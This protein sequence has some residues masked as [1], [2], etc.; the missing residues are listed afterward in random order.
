MNSLL[1]MLAGRQ[2]DSRLPRR[3]VVGSELMWL[4]VLALLMGGCSIQK[5]AVNA[6]GDSLASSGDVF[7]SDE[8]PELV[9]DA[10]PF[11]MKTIEMLL[12]E[13]PDHRQLLLSACSLFT[14]YANLFVQVDAEQLEE[15]DYQESERQYRRALGLYLRGRGYCFRSLELAWPGIVDRLATDPV[16]A[17]EVFDKPDVPLIF[18][19]GASWGGAIAIGMDRPDLVADFPAVQALM[20]RALALDESYDHGAIHGV[21]ITL[22]SLPESMGGSPDQ[23]RFHFERAV[24]LSNGYSVGPYVSLAE[25]VV[26]AAQDWEEFR[27]LLET[28]LAIDPDQAPAMRLLNVIGQQR[29]QWLLERIDRFF[30]DY[31]AE[32]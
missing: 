15:I 21:L 2:K 5:L 31:P 4:V 32:D 30:I 28:A 6:L 19:T 18:L 29:A 23:A 11:T 22:N 14:G 13:N 27:D 7:T 25:S 26:V 10:M 3:L 20:D 17:V 9:R 8:D 24:E 12:A 1:L 16:A